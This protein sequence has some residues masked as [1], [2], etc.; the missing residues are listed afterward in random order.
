MFVEELLCITAPVLKVARGQAGK[1]P[2]LDSYFNIRGTRPPGH[3]VSPKKYVGH[4]RVFHIPYTIVYPVHT[5]QMSFSVPNSVG[6]TSLQAMIG[7]QC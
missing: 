3:P 5:Q 4:H 2:C 7:S 6:G 1:G